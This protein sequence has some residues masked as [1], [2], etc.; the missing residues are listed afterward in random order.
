MNIDKFDLHRVKTSQHAK[1]VRH[2]SLRFKVT[3]RTQKRTHTY[4][5]RIALTGPQKWSVKIW[6]IEQTNC[7]RTA[8]SYCNVIYTV[9]QFLWCFIFPPHLTSASSLPGKTRKHEKSHI[10]TQML[11]LLF[12]NQSLFDFFNFVDFQLIFTLL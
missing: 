10:F 6:P 2:R 8:R 5:H 3:V 1:Y 7:V 12:F 4:T 9:S 11:L